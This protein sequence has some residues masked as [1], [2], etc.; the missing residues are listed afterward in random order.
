MQAGDIISITAK[1]VLNDESG[2]LSHGASLLQASSLVKI[3]AMAPY[4]VDVDDTCI[5]TATSIGKF[6]LSSA[7]ELRRDKRSFVHI[8]LLGSYVEIRVVFCFLV[9]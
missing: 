5:Y 3:K 7:W 2:C 1:D 9:V 6:T 8:L 4:I